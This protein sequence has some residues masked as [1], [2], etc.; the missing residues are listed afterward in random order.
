MQNIVRAL[1][2]ALI[3]SLFIMRPIASFADDHH[4]DGDGHGHDHGHYGG[5]DHSYIGVNFSVWPDS[6]YYGAPYYPS[7][8]EVLVSPPVYQPIVINGAT[9]YLNDG[10]YY[11]YNG[12]G[13]Q[14]V[15]PPV[16]VVQPPQVV[17]EAAPATP[18]ITTVGTA[19]SDAEGSFTINIPNDKGGYTA[20]TLKRSGNGF[21]GPQGE[22]YPDFPKVSQLK[23][24]Y[25]K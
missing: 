2:A 14:P 25:G 6:Y 9:Y 20:V 4:H 21:I 3:I 10:S 22:F 5:H 24:I 1:F 19:V 15:A 13:Y 18:V 17:T 7:A 8:D 11:V 12:Y 16:T 23:V